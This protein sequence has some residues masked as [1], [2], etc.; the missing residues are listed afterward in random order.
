MRIAIVNR[1][2]S[3]ALGGSETQCDLIAGRLCRRHAVRYVAPGGVMGT[4]PYDAVGV[5]E[6]S[7][8]V[9]GAISEFRPDVVYWRFGTRFLPAALSS[10]GGLDAPVVLA[11]SHEHDLQRW[12]IPAGAP[13]PR[14]RLLHVRDR[15][16]SAIEHRSLRRLAGLVVN[17]EAHLERSCI[18][19]RR[20]IPNSLGVEAVDFIWP[21]PYVAWVANLKPDKRPEHCIPLAR[22]IADIGVDL[23]M[24]GAP[25]VAA[26]ADFAL[27]SDL[28]PN[29]HVL[30]PLPGPEAAGVLAGALLHVHTCRPEGF[31]NVFLQ[32]W[33]AGV[34]SVS[35]EYDPA[36]VIASEGVGAVA[37][38]SATRM[39][40]QVR[41]I[42]QDEQRRTD[43]GV[44]AQAYARRRG[45]LDTNVGA[46]ERFLSDIVTMRTRESGR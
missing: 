12:G 6:R 16:R 45:D 33:G 24:V 20:F 23:L 37:D 29:L 25:Q 27:R 9:L 14:G 2:P 10:R 30:G 13:G 21:R 46:L 22:G 11:S 43:L 26:Y 34:P 32:A 40:T 28:P 15:L 3:V 7:A 35:L 36:G 4:A 44:R 17:T 5:A 8:P 38:G 19:P 31:P 39:L 42:L 1:H 18:E 41:S